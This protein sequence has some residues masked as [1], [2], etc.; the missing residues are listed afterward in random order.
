M[1]DK[2][3]A[4]DRAGYPRAE[5]ARRLGKRYQH[6]RNVLEGDKLRGAAPRETASSAPL[7]QPKPAHSFFPDRPQVF[8]IEVSADGVLTLP[9][10]LRAAL[11]VTE[12]GVLLG[13]MN[14]PDLML[15]DAFAAAERARALVLLLDKGSGSAVDSL[16]S[17]RRREAAMEADD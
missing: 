13:R 12:C 4:L 6:V 16:I 1:A 10:P 7:A 2:I 15:T 17:D 3:R 11:K 5:I 8:R 14:G 9:E